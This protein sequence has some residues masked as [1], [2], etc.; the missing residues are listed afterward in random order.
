MTLKQKTVLFVFCGLAAL[1][2][3]PS[4]SRSKP[5]IKYGFISLVLFEGAE[6]PLPRFSFFI[7]PEDED[8]IENLE[9]L[10]LYHD[11][12][13]LRWLIKSDDWI[14]Y[15]RDET[16]WIGTRSIALQDDESLPGGQYR[17]VLVN[18][19]GERGERY[20][21]FDGDARFPFP[22]LEIIN[23]RFFVSSSWP[24]NRLVFFDNEGVHI[25]TVELSWLSGN[26]SD[27]DLPPNT[28][29]AALWAEDPDRF[30]SA[31]TNVVSIR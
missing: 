26:V 31:Y 5:E 28:I 20:F 17:A 30:C 13:Q 18:K 2:S 19:G 7:I 1:F 14:T 11:R 8:G 23:G 25:S 4:C 29:V 6:K 24:V 12:E 15:K 21:T 16:T 3:F 22:S 9:T 27:F 10:Y